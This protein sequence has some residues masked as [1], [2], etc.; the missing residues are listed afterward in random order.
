MGTEHRFD[1]LLATVGCVAREGG[2]G[3][4]ERRAGRELSCRRNSIRGYYDQK[5]MWT[6][7]LTADDRQLRRPGPVR[8]PCDQLRHQR[9]PAAARHFSQSVRVLRRRA[10]RPADD[11]GPADI[12]F[13]P[14]RHGELTLAQARELLVSTPDALQWDCFRFGIIQGEDHFTFYVSFDHVHV[15]AV[16]VGGTLMEFYMMYAA[17]MGGSA[18]IRCRKRVA[19]TTSVSGSG[20]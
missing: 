18:P 10:D 16:I 3:A 11:R 6:R 2:P 13:V 9:A 5:A 17:L 20:R 12:E 14:V 4:G 7:L 15:D 1:R 8:H 19:S